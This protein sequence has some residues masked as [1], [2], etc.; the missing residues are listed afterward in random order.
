MDSFIKNG[1]SRYTANHANK[2][3]QNSQVHKNV[4]S[5]LSTHNL[6]LNLE[7]SGHSRQESNQKMHKLSSSKISHGS[8]SGVSNNLPLPISSSSGF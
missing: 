2:N 8:R 3:L 7:K 5:R 1:E 6:Q 4:E